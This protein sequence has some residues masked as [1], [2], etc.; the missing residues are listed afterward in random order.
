[1]VNTPNYTLP[2]PAL[3]D[4]PNGPSQIGS[5]ATAID[6]L[7]FSTFAA[8]DTAL[9]NRL[10]NLVG[11]AVATTETTTSVGTFVNLATVGPSITLTTRGVAFAIWGAQM[12]ASVGTAGNRMSV[13]VSGATT[14]ASQTANAA[15]VTSTGSG[16]AFRGIGFEVFILN[17]GVNTFTA[18]YCV[19]S[20][21]TGTFVNRKLAVWA[22]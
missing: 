9:S 8:Q 19:S 5:L 18:Q 21:A 15:I 7:L 4:A 1:M 2:Y 16:D 13:A 3:S 12:F 17:P 11:A 10:L 6:T 14:I 22:P 20:A